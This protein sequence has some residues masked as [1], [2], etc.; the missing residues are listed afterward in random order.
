MI[1]RTDEI[2]RFTATANDG[3]LHT[4][5]I[6]QEMIAAGTLACPDAVIP[7]LRIYSTSTG[8]HVNCID[9]QTFWIIE[10]SEIARKV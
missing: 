8:L 4:I 9:P 10:I 7:G 6:H 5:I 3:T 2:D 1:A